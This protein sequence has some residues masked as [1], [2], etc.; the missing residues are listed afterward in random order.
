[1]PL[2]TAW[3]DTDKRCSQNVLQ[4]SAPSFLDLE[5]LLGAGYLSGVPKT[6]RTNSAILESTS[7][8]FSISGVLFISYNKLLTT[9]WVSGLYIYICKTGR[10]N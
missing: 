5:E 4:I 6:P 7:F 2:Q 3:Y 1:M 8:G 10:L 9:S